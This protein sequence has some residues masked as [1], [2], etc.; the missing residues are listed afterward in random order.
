M[1]GRWT[2][3]CSGDHGAVPSLDCLLQISFTWERSTS[4]F[5]TFIT[6]EVLA[7]TVKIN[8]NWWKM[9]SQFGVLLGI[10][11]SKQ[12]LWKLKHR[13]LFFSLKPVKNY[14]AVW[15]C[16]SE[17][18]FSPAFCSSTLSMLA[19][20]LMPDTY[21]CKMAAVAPAIMSTWQARKRWKSQSFAPHKVLSFYLERKFLPRRVPLTSHYYRTFCTSV[22]GST[23]LKPRDLCQ[24]P[25]YIRFCY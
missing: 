18:K 17:P 25:K 7:K 9:K 23:L 6:W 22:V 11:N 1:V 2:L 20:I 24:L 12:S 5:K 4:V 15:W 8:T 21:G 10:S 3:V 14:M 19:F 13:G 16:H